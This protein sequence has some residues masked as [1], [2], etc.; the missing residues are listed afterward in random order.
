MNPPNS[1]WGGII[2]RYAKHLPVSASTPIV[3][4]DEGNTLLVRADNFVKAA[5]GDWHRAGEEKR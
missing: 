1:R 4:L 3:T 5:G 2:Q